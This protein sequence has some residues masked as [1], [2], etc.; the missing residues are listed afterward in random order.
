MVHFQDNRSM[1]IAVE[2]ING[3]HWA[4]ATGERRRGALEG[5]FKAAMLTPLAL[6]QGDLA[7]TETVVEKGLSA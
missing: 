5:L 7:K 3:D 4:M 6:A 2:L 1:P